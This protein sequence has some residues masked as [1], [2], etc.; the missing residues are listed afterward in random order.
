MHTYKLYIDEH[1]RGALLTKETVKLLAKQRNN[2]FRK[3]KQQTRQAKKFELT[4]KNMY[5]KEN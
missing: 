2:F 5:I 3:E 1:F 4:E